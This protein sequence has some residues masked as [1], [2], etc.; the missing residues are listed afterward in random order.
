VHLFS[1]KG[2]ILFLY[3][4]GRFPPDPLPADLGHGPVARRGAL[5]R[6]PVALEA[7]IIASGGALDEHG[8]A[9]G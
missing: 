8:S 2:D 7:L 5:I 9:N 4:L 3:A 1:G 6:L